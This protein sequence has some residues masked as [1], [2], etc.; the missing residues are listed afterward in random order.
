MSES[1]VLWEPSTESVDGS[2]MTAYMR[3]LRD[4]RGLSFEDYDALWKWSVE[5]LPAFWETVAEF[6][7]VHFHTPPDR[8]LSG[9][10]MPGAKWFEGARLNYAEHL[11]RRDDDHP[12][13]IY[14]CEDGTR[15]EWSFGELRDQVARVRAG[16]RRLGVRQGDRVVGYIANIPEAVASM[17]AT[18]SLGA[19]W[20][21]C[22]PEFGVGSVLDR[23]RQLEPSVLIAVDG[24][25]Y[26]GKWFDRRKALDEIVSGLSSLQ[27]TVVLPRTAGEPPAA[28]RIGYAELAG[29]SG[30][31]DFEPVPFEHPLWVLYSSGTT[32]LPKGIVH[33]HGGI[34]LE[35]YKQLALHTDLKPED[36][37]FWF[38]TTGWMMW[39]YLVGGL[40]LGSTIVLYEG[41]PAHPDLLALFRLAGEE[42]LTYLGI[43]APFLMAC[44]KAGLSPKEEVRLDELR[45]IGSTGSPLSTEGFRWVYEHVKQDLWLGSLSGG[46]DVC[47]GFVGPCP[48]LP[49]RTGELQCRSLGA[50]VEAFD[51]GGRPVLDEVGELVLTRP[52]PSMPVCFWNDPDGQRYRDSYFDVYPGVW[53]HGDWIELKSRG[54]T[55]IHG[56]SDS[57]LNRGGVRMGTS[58]F[59]RVVEG[60]SEIRDSVVIDTGSLE[61]EGKLW[62]F[63]VPAEGAEI[64]DALVA[65][66]RT[67][68]RTK[69]SPRHVPDEIRAIPEVPR[70]LSGK[71]LEVP[72]K[73]ILTGTPP[74]QAV[75][76]GTLS[77]PASIESLLA[78]T[79]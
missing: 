63:V 16:L 3:W 71:K 17:L 66:I 67:E 74:A 55:V 9:T 53:R 5:E 72:I 31:L 10:E 30:P 15:E 20:S 46:T 60:L 77:N 18:T 11:L 54:G 6:F 29:E 28:G 41:A 58:E 35:H 45:G 21:S 78:A 70:T 73:R 7:D 49:V 12:A 4:R 76:P 64:D 47:T 65:R 24:Y 33:G 39:N 61:E 23:L 27:A 25:P 38:T 14:R 59:Y 48:L 26:N 43:G 13:L 79:E 52:M 22:P 50:K 51:S 69:L 36:R 56:R 19:V 75:N 37:F 8:V 57:T 62:L 44:C 68:L 42:K 40:L 2:N 1:E 34:L 32:G